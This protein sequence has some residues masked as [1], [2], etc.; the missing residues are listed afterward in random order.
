MKITKVEILT[1][2]KPIELPIPWRPAWS[3]PSGPHTNSFNL[4]LY[5]VYTDQGIV[6]YGPNIGGNPELIKNQDPFQIRQF[7][8]HHMGGK[9]AGNSGKRA[10]GLEIA[11]WDIIGKVAKLPISH[12]LGAKLQKIPVYAATSRL[13]DTKQQVEQ[14]KSLIDLGFKAIKLRLHRSNPLDDLAMISAVRNAVGDQVNILVD[15]NQNNA[16]SSIGDEY[17]FWSRRTAMQMATELD[18]LDV[19]FLEEPLPRKDI[20]GLSRIS[21]MVEMMVAG[22]EHTPTVSDFSPHLL[23][24]AYDIVQPDITLTG[25]FGIIGLKEIASTADHY[26]RLIIPHVTGGGAFFIMFAATLQVMATVDNCPMIEFPFD[27][28]ILTP[29]TLQSVLDEPFWIDEDGS[30]TVPRQPGLGIEINEDSLETTLAWEL[31]S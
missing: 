1:N 14:V 4:S 5:K 18:Q 8:S 11:L 29:E 3:E 13:L 7:W 10:A 2:S 23:A 31:K 25:N 12:L 26:G 19:F 20:E 17:E 27:P 21:N 24:G 6:G 15:A 22:G 16:S 28:P 30:I 9:R